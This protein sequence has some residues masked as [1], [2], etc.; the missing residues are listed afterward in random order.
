MSVT[1]AAAFAAST[2]TSQTPW[3]TIVLA[4]LSG[5][6]AAAVL[7]SLGRR[8]GRRTG[9]LDACRDLRETS[10]RLRI[11]AKELG[12]AAGPDR[13][14]LDTLFVDAVGRYRFAYNAMP[15]DELRHRAETWARLALAYYGGDEA[16]TIADEFR[17]W[18]DFAERWGQVT[19]STY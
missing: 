13:P 14:L 2:S 6:V 7:S 3:L 8:A 18:D 17:A 1:S 15:D 12:E 11:A 5:S 19:M 9:L 4:L 10:T 16:V